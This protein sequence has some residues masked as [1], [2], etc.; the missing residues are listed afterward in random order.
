[1]TLSI[2]LNTNHVLT[3]CAI[4]LCMILTACTQVPDKIQQAPLKVPPSIAHLSILTTPKDALV[5]ILNTESTYQDGIALLPGSYQIEVSS[6]DYQPHTE[7]IQLGHE[8][9]THRVVLKQYPHLFVK[10]EPKNAQIRL[11]N[12][13]P[14]YQDGMT[15]PPGSYQIEVTHPGYRKAM[16]WITLGSD[17]Q[18]IR[19][20]LKKIPPKAPAMPPA[21][22]KIE[23]KMEWIKPGCFQM[24]S[25]DD[26]AGRYT[27]ET[28]HFVCL[29]QGYYL[30]KYEVT[31]QLWR[32]IMGNNPAH[33][34]SCGNRC[35]V[36]NVSW[37]DVQAFIAKLNQLTGLHYRLPTEAEWEYAARAGGI[38]ATYNGDLTIKGWYSAPELDAIA[39]YGGNSGATYKN[40]VDCKDWPDKQHGADRCGTH[41]VGLKKA[42]VW[43]LYDMLGNVMEWVQDGYEKDYYRHSPT[44]DPQGSPSNAYHVARGGSWRSRTEFVRSANRS[45]KPPDR[46]KNNLGFRLART[47]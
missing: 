47:P 40:A 27:D 28:Q 12:I 17:D 39:W 7:W 23:I 26:E 15:L 19:V 38:P 35:P 44:D 2:K 29:T 42:N 43:G 34:Q 16:E 20:T 10:A 41:P 11:L 18:T 37:N 25:P 3:V 46:R 36:E 32:Q 33:F 8:N 24:G 21:P 1:M 45:G 13:K 30:G 9:L 14:V 5:R 31:Q 6:P 4:S 22:D